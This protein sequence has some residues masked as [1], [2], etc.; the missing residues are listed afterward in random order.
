[1]GESCKTSRIKPTDRFISCFNPI[2][3]GGKMYVAF[4]PP[5][6]LH[7]KKL[8]KVR[9][10]FR[11]LE[12]DRKV[13]LV[14][15]HPSGIYI[16]EGEV[17]MFQ[18]GFTVVKGLLGVIRVANDMGVYDIGAIRGR[19]ITLFKDNIYAYAGAETS[20]EKEIADKTVVKWI[21]Y[22]LKIMLEPLLGRL[23]FEVK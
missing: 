8:E 12:A 19:K 5:Y 23:E 22:R 16:L 10:M 18:E 15:H 17:K 9:S 11:A 14:F 7:G 2:M 20:I 21:Q 6:P 1:M 4:F 3:F 13:T